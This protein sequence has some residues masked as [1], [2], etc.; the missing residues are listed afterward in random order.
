LKKNYNI[1][2]ESH[3]TILIH[4]LEKGS[5]NCYSG[6]HKYDVLWGKFNDL[7]ALQNIKSMFIL[8]SPGGV[9]YKLCTI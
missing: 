4:R 6:S 3:N 8:N 9:I 2:T 1:A 5:L 7:I